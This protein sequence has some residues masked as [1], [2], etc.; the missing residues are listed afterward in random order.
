MSA[1]WA[2]PFRRA[3]AGAGHAD[4][5]C[6]TAQLMSDLCKG[7]AVVISGQTVGCD[8]QLSVSGVRGDFE[9]NYAEQC[10]SEGQ[11]VREPVRSQ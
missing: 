6:V 1:R 8:D 2:S 5:W 11:W 7:A 10:A 4:V 9:R 3:G